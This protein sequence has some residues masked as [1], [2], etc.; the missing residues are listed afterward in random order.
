MTYDTLMNLIICNT[1]M[2]QTKLHYKI[3]PDFLANN[4]R[5]SI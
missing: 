3:A 5:S 4:T 1:V 2:F